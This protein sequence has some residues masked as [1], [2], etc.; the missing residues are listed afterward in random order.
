MLSIIKKWQ[1]AFGVSALL[2]VYPLNQALADTA[3]NPAADGKLTKSELEVAKRAVAGDLEKLQ[4]R[5]MA[6][7]TEDLS[8]DGRAIPAA[9]MLMDD[10][11]VKNINIADIDKIS[12][13]K[14][15]LEAYRSALRAVARHDK[16][17]AASLGY[18]AN[19]KTES[20]HE[21]AIV[22]EYEHRLGVAGQRFVAY[23]F[24][25][26]NGELKLGKP[27]DGSKPFRWFYT[28]KKK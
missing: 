9:V 15:I 19:I 17:V 22:T 10:G 5:L 8:D 13:P 1:V 20:S 3:I 7:M 6:D 4:K 18:T 26:A 11:T 2:L 21:L 25:S 27:M 28:S 23:Q 14:L 24:D 12:D 16:I